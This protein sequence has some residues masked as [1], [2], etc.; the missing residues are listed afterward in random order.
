[1]VDRFAL[2]WPPKKET[3]ETEQDEKRQRVRF[4]TQNGL[5]VSEKDSL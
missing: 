2:F 1:L 4:D 5:A 3:K